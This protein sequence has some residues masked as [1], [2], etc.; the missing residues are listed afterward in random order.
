M[1]E[2]D[3][4]INQLRNAGSLG[5]KPLTDEEQ[6]R[7]IETAGVFGTPSRIQ[8]EVI[9]TPGEA[10]S[11]GV[12]AGAFNLKANTES[13]KAAVNTLIGR[14]K[15][16]QDQLTQAEYIQ[17]DAANL[18]STMEPFDVFLEQP[19]FTGFINQV[20]AATGQFVPS[21]I[22]SIAAA[23]ATGGAA[24]GAAAL[25]GR[26]SIAKLTT[27]KKA[28]F[29]KTVPVTIESIRQ[30][31]TAAEIRDLLNRSYKNA[32]ANK[33][34]K[35]LPFTITPKE[36]L[37][38]ENTVYPALKREA[39]QR[40]GIRGAL[41]GAFAQEQ[42]QG[43]GIA[44]QDYAEQ[45]MTSAN[46]VIK[47]FAQGSIFAGIGVG[48]EVLV[49]RS[50]V[51]TLKKGTAKL[52]PTLTKEGIE[53]IFK[54]GIK[55]DTSFLKDMFRATGTTAFSEGIAEA[56]Q[57]ELSVQQKFSIDDAYTQANAKLD[58]IQ[59]LFAG[60]FGGVGVG[61]GLGTGPAVLNKS[62]QLLNDRAYREFR[63]QTYDMRAQMQQ[64]RPDSAT[65]L[66]FKQRA[67]AIA[68]EF[69][70]MFNPKMP[71]INTQYTDIDSEAEFNKALA[72]I[73]RENPGKMDNIFV[74]PRPAQGV[75]FTTSPDIAEIA[76]NIFQTRPYDNE[77]HNEFLATAL[78]Y[79]RTKDSIDDAVVGAFDK[80]ANEFVKFQTTSTRI[81][82]PDNKTGVELAK[83]KMKNLLGSE[84]DG[85]NFDVITQ[86][87]A[88]H[89]EFRKKG[90]VL[91]TTQINEQ[92][93][94]VRVAFEDIYDT[95]DVDAP[96]T[97]EE[98]EE[99][100]A[101]EADK[102]AIEQRLSLARSI[103]ARTLTKTQEAAVEEYFKE[104]FP[105]IS[106]A[107][108]TF[109]DLQNLEAYHGMILDK[110]KAI[111]A[112][113]TGVKLDSLAELGDAID[114]IKAE[115]YKQAFKEALSPPQK[116]NFNRISKLIKEAST[117]PIGAERPDIS[118]LARG[119]TEAADNP[120][121]FAI[122]TVEQILANIAPE[123]TP[124]T[125]RPTGIEVAS[126]SVASLNSSEAKPVPVTEIVR[127]TTLPIEFE[128]PETEVAREEIEI[129]P[130]T[131]E[132]KIKPV[133]GLKPVR[134]EYETRDA[135]EDALTTYVLTKQ[136]ARLNMVDSDAIATRGGSGTIDNPY[137]Q[138]I[139]RENRSENQEPP[140]W[141]NYSI[142]ETTPKADRRRTE[143]QINQSYVHVLFR[144]EIDA[145]KDNFSQ[146]L[147]D[148]FAKKAQALNDRTEGG[149][150]LRIVPADYLSEF[151]S[152]TKAST[153]FVEIP[154]DVMRN[155]KEFVFVKHE[156]ENSNELVR[157]NV[158]E[159]RD[160]YE[161]VRTRI[162][163]AKDRAG[164]NM[165]ASA[166]AIYKFSIFETREFGSREAA[167]DMGVLLEGIYTI[168]KITGRRQEEEL[169]LT[170][171]RYGKNIS[172][173]RATAFNDF[174]NFAA[175][176]GI[177]VGY[178]AQGYK[179]KG[180]G[181]KLDI[182]GTPVS[183]VEA[184]ASALPQD[185][186]P[187]Q[188]IKFYYDLLM[189]PNTLT[190]EGELDR[191]SFSDFERSLADGGL[192]QREIDAIKYGIK[193]SIV[194]SANKRISKLNALP[195]NING[196]VYLTE[197]GNGFI[198]SIEPAV[199]QDRPLLVAGVNGLFVEVDPNKIEK[200]TK[201]Y[202]GTKVFDYAN[203]D[204][205]GT[206]E[207]FEALERA[208]K[209][210]TLLNEYKIV[211]D[212]E[213]VA[214][215][216]D[217][218]RTQYNIFMGP[219]YAGRGF[220]QA[221]INDLK[222]EG[223]SK[224][225][226]NNISSQIR[227][228]HVADLQAQYP[229]LGIKGIEKNGSTLSLTAKGK[230]LLK[231]L[232]PTATRL[233]VGNHG[234][235]IEMNKPANVGKFVKK[236]LQY[237][238]YKRDGVKLY[239]QFKTVNYANY[240]TDKWYADPKEYAE[241]K[242]E[243]VQLEINFDEPTINI[244]AGTKENAHLSNFAPRP[245][246]GPNGRDYIS[247][248]H[249]YQSNKTGKFNKKVS[250]EFV[251]LGR[252][253]LKSWLVKNAGKPKTKDNANLKLMKNL[254][255]ASFEQNP[256]EL[257]KLIATGDTT[258]THIG[259]DK[260]FEKRFPQI[261]MEVREELGA[262]GNQLQMDL[263]AQAPVVPIEPKEEES[264]AYYLLEDKLKVEEKARNI[265][266]D[267]TALDLIANDLNSGI[268]DIKSETLS[269]S[270]VLNSIQTPFDP[271]ASLE[272]M[273]KNGR[274]EPRPYEKF[275]N[276]EKE[277]VVSREDLLAKVGN[278][279]YRVDS[280]GQVFTRAD[281]GID[282]DE[283]ASIEDLEV[284]TNLMPY[285]YNRIPPLDFDVATYDD[286]VNYIDDLVNIYVVDENKKPLLIE[287]S[288][289]TALSN[290][291]EASSNLIVNPNTVPLINL[292]VGLGSADLTKRPKNTRFPEHKVIV[293]GSRNFSETEVFNKTLDKLFGKNKNI[294]IVSGMAKGA[295]TL[296][297]E[298]AKDKNLNLVKF[299]IKKNEKPTN[300]N[301]RMAADS[302]SAVI[303]FSNI[304]KPSPGSF[305]MLKKSVERFGPANVFIFDAAGR[306]V[307]TVGDM[308]KARPQAVSATGR[309]L[310]E[311]KKLDYAF[312]SGAKKGQLSKAKQKQYEA[313]I[314]EYQAGLAR[315]AHNATLANGALRQLAP[316]MLLKELAEDVSMRQ[317]D[318]NS[319]TMTAPINS[320]IGDALILESAK[321]HREPFLGGGG[322]ISTGMYQNELE[323]LVIAPPQGIFP[324]E[325]LDKGAFRERQEQ[326]NIERMTGQL[327]KPMK[328]IK[329][330]QATATP[331]TETPQGEKYKKK[332][333]TITGRPFRVQILDGITTAARRLGLLT[334]IKILQDNEVQSWM[335][336]PNFNLEGFEEIRKDFLANPKKLGMNVKYK[337]FDVIVLKNN[338][339][340]TD[341]S[342]GE[343][344]M[345]FM[346]ELGESFVGQ[347]L[348]KTLKVKSTRD[349]LVKEFEKAKAAKN[350]PQKYQ[351]EE[352]GFDEFIADQFAIAI[353]KKLGI[354][355]N[356]TA[357]TQFEKMDLPI[358][359]W[360]K[361][362]VRQLESFF[363]AMKKAATKG[364]FVMNETVQEYIDTVALNITDP[365]SRKI[366]YQ[367]KAKI[368]R[369]IEDLFGPETFTQKSLNSLIKQMNKL[370]SAENMP[371]WLKQIFY[372]ADNRLRSLG[373]NLPK[374]E[375]GRTVGEALADFYYARSRTLTA[376][377]LLMIKNAKAQAYV[378]EVAK[379]LNAKDSWLYA[380]LNSSQRAIL[381]EAE[382][383]K[384]TKDISEP[385]QKVRAVF[386][387][388][389]DELGLKDL[390]VT[391]RDNFFPRLIAIYDIGGD[392]GIR[393]NLIN[394]LMKKNPKVTRAQV[395]EAITELV[396]KGKNEID[397]EAA[398]NDPLDVGILKPYKDL[399]KNVTTDELR[400]IKAAEPPEVALKKYFDKAVTRSVFE[401]K[402][403]VKYLRN[404]MNKLSPEE[405]IEAQNIQD[406][407]MGR[408]SPISNG[409]LRL[410]NNIGLVINVVTLLGFAVLASLPDLAG[411]VLRSRTLDTSQLFNAIKN[412]A[413]NRE[414]MIELAKE[415]GVVGVDAMS[416]FFINAGEVDFMNEKAKTIANGFFRLTG[417]EAFTRFSRV[418]A[419]GM[420]KQF[421]IKHAEKAKR[422]DTT[423]ETYLAELQV[424]ADEVLAWSEG[425]ASPAV[426]EKVNQGLVRFVDESIVR[427]NAAE[428]PVWA[429]DPRY[430]LLWQL[431]SFYYAYGKT[432]MGGVF[433]DS[434]NNAKTAGAGAAVMP[435]LF[436]AMMLLPIT[437][438]GWEIREFT[439]AGLAWLLPGISPDDA[440]V[441]YYR[442]NTMT[443]GQYWT[444]AIDRTGM[445]GPVS[446]ALPVFLEDHRHGKP[447][448]LS[449][450]GPTAERLYDGITWDWKV[451]DYIPGY[452]QL[453]TRALG[454]N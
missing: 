71:K 454:R 452:S 263:Q 450:L 56:L 349:K 153:E 159:F 287:A 316:L 78:G 295:D 5:R 45:G 241:L 100:Q 401:E 32:L 24:T 309:P 33:K 441:N 121:L 72:Q 174:L 17:T 146:Q 306:K 319:V 61:A 137:K 55:T 157:R 70:H 359:S 297:V 103:R 190:K 215:E 208:E 389:F 440:G 385:A 285:M 228:V 358:K 185:I 275:H 276:V 101:S 274:P 305:D 333:G 142:D 413:Q 20:A 247:V 375:D 42:V 90:L 207:K 138:Y 144:D 135:Y 149:N 127:R 398:T 93:E 37:L 140:F 354:R 113:K 9:D 372:A 435:L 272:Y 57:E 453:D 260:Y 307:Y 324:A 378:N 281:D 35:E 335:N 433:R 79:T 184:P 66:I 365:S 143:G 105:I 172:F 222:K 223:K 168:F 283:P 390:G 427:P 98:Q 65:S 111:R 318:P 439:K 210:F 343:Y 23:A 258:L 150:F 229:Q 396:A 112:E 328:P 162:K 280:K 329:E 189:N 236:R 53:E 267:M 195:P 308:K 245:F 8:P 286:L 160:I 437:M 370:M 403:G 165:G 131:Q 402:G 166:D 163:Q 428:R 262:P 96:L 314:V 430:A 326:M 26:T 322:A 102:R 188:T 145:A 119:L 34:G 386:K 338:I 336:N 436:V 231:K 406:A 366:P 270:T 252:T 201:T 299:P 19:T 420:G 75:L 383:D 373:K 282:A 132:E 2:V 429:S 251:R 246:V 13:F 107:G 431:K 292:A 218:D 379:A 449:P 234:V 302:T 320:W 151:R 187:R 255:K 344:Y 346:H 155:A 391:Y 331:I 202:D 351:D 87:I 244:F 197:E 288:S 158:K 213:Q 380:T 278:I 235:Y 196:E 332:T 374:L 82:G 154:L 170:G 52:K 80:K 290:I 180:P 118:P 423:S 352:T 108:V 317:E 36:Q 350:A 193:E 337:D 99:Q 219:K 424:T 91:D 54:T 225:E 300:R 21:A 271:L 368:E 325:G 95:D 289:N 211:P 136:E 27:G 10:F 347:E 226:I 392:D 233:M 161:D 125:R 421:M 355:V 371:K 123:E 134:D 28:P 141:K 63:R 206:K 409:F 68:T 230:G 277:S 16:A 58:R 51:D 330:K 133:M 47:S 115:D 407:I 3:I 73:E 59:A 203:L 186:T 224:S 388:A 342:D 304:G 199:N 384:A 64:G 205:K 451:A 425:K 139:P 164:S 363:N 114:A 303:F 156:I 348:E 200:G 448:W 361:R 240:K 81:E 77:F 177:Y 85:K 432:I 116:R 293:A 6:K 106:S 239:D 356:E 415:I 29:L 178:S 198:K 416:T 381:L 296:A 25:T 426:R 220:Y 62:R 11:A 22:V 256:T 86:S 88:Q 43:T 334:N 237:N 377:G 173:R 250:D 259:G 397:F 394:L 30:Q 49:A 266:R 128:T 399:F 362:L 179:A 183:Q 14:D 117:L 414:E 393:A 31:K 232:E 438:L 412:H 171:K 446:M 248:E 176:N 122:S 419:T 418:F 257:Q 268:Y 38:L 39:A 265:I 104:T 126:E 147:V 422:G 214:E 249:G 360:F 44:F 209:T 242:T 182:V 376:S 269:L 216:P 192:Q 404:L 50:I 444:E 312:K 204:A 284:A 15:V 387:K 321:R 191:K 74:V 254:I 124:S 310:F 341:V 369:Q 1:N 97:P 120:G 40:I 311:P 130:E 243:P 291:Q 400:S 345:T 48:S 301:T 110:T 76:R 395:E 18:M 175:D 94:P 84:Y 279:V 83:E 89:L 238:E 264:T 69:R 364:N 382:S 217:L 340:G 353:R 434:M 405:Q 152:Q 273:I 313:A 315:G 447:F 253:P 109:K 212:V 298:Y 60:F 181:S 357:D 339:A 408:I 169:E 410:A 227:R 194:E 41:A 4:A 411:P 261:L 12:Q 445:L 442:T 323:N 167:V 67:A 417:L 46:D 367:T 92:G 294:T 148:D 221:F 7:Q 443:N 129:D 327:Y